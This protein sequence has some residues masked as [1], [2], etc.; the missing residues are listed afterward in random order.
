[1]KVHGNKI[2]IINTYRHKV[3]RTKRRKIKRECV[4][5]KED[6]IK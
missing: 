1:M 3:R 4:H 5:V 2:I 6:K